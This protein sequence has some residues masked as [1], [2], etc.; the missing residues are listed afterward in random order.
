MQ[1]KVLLQIGRDW[2][3]EQ[4]QMCQ[5]QFLSDSSLSQ[6]YN[7]IR[8][9][10][11]KKVFFPQIMANN[12]YQGSD[13]FAALHCFLLGYNAFIASF[14]CL[15]GKQGIKIKAEAIKCCKE[16]KITAPSNEWSNIPFCLS[17]AV[18]CLYTF[19]SYSRPDISIFL[20]LS[21][22]NLSLYLDIDFISEGHCHSCWLALAPGIYI[23]FIRFRFH[24]KYLTHY[25]QI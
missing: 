4:R 22:W 10:I 5:N 6:P 17:I 21:V 14:L 2:V 1:R 11:K 13:F 16:N 9:T 20:Y 19:H 25:Y 8:A 18:S 12:S 3:G 15:E 7:P 24:L 23:V